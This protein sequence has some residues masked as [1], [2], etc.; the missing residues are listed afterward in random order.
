MRLFPLDPGYEMRRCADAVAAIKAVT[1]VE[2]S[3]M[4]VVAL[5]MWI[6]RRFAL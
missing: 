6:Y 4:E 2:P 1:K 3:I 5:D